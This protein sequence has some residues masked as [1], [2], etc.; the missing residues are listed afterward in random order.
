MKQDIDEA[1]LAPPVAKQVVNPHKAPIRE[2]ALLE[3]QYTAIHAEDGVF[4]EAK[5]V[6]DEWVV[7]AGQVDREN[8]AHHQGGKQ[9]I[10]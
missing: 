1:L 7:P 6:K 10:G 2:H 4:R 9:K 3:G 5:V 8:R